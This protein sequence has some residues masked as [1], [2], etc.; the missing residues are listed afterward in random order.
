MRGLALFGVVF[1]LANAA[2]A[3]P[4]FM[5]PYGAGEP[6]V[7]GEPGLSDI[8][9]LEIDALAVGDLRI[10]VRMSY[11][12]GDTALAPFTGSVG[13]LAGITLAP[14]DVLFEGR[15]FLWAI[16]LAGP[17]GAP[18]GGYLTA[19]AVPAAEGTPRAV[20]PGG[21][22]RVP[23]FRTSGD[24]L[25]L[26]PGDDFRAGEPVWGVIGSD[27][28]ESFG[29]VTASS[30]GGAELDVRLV[31]MASAAFVADV[32]DGFRVHLASTTCA[33]DVL[34]AVYPA[35]PEPGRGA[36]ALC[37]GLALLGLRRV[38]V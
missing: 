23:G 18:G 38:R 24:V 10:T 12:G 34:D 16:P 4:L 20:F 28:P 15:D 35:V 36:L 17:S 29:Y 2:A 21:L 32:S 31:V 30:A 37:A 1:W 8:R 33:C 3:G 25:G 11:G 22:Y 5:D 26:A 6:D 19:A 13:S 7:L 9:S 14:G 27:L